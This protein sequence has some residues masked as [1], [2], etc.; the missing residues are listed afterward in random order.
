MC[1]ELARAARLKPEA[2]FTVG[3][4]SLLDA[5]MDMP[6]DNLVAALPLA[7]EISEAITH[8]RGELGALLRTVECYER[9]DWAAVDSDQRL[10]SSDLTGAWH[11]A[12]AWQHQLRE[13]LAVA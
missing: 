6:L 13:Q 8:R 5:L 10:R 3:L 7:P 9:G 4:F 2:A 12:L 1:E 11:A